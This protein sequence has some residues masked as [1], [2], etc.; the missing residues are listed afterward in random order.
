MMPVKNAA[1]ILAAALFV[2][3]VYSQNQGVVEGRLI[4]GTNPAKALAGLSVDAV[5]PASGMSAL[6]SAKTDSSGKFQFNGLPTIGPLLIRADYREVSYFSPVTFDERG[7]AQIEMRV[8]ETTASA[9]GIR[10]ANLQIAFKLASDGLRSIESYEIDNQ[11]K[12][13]STFMR[14]DG[15]FRF[16]KAPGIT[17]PPSLDVTS[18]GSSMPVTQAPLES[19]DGQSYYSLYALKPGMT[20]FEV[21]QQFPWQNGGFTFRKKFYQDV[22]SIKIGVIPQDMTLSG[23]GLARVQ[24]DATQNFAI[25]AIG[26]IKAGTEVVW[27]LS[28]GTPVA[29]APAPSSSQ[30]PEVQVMPMPNLI[31]QNALIIG[32]LLLLG[33]VLVL[34][35]ASSRVIVQPAGAKD[36]RTQEL[37]DRR[38][39][40]LNYIAALDA[41]YEKKALD[42]RRYVRLREQGKRHLRRIAVL[43]EKKR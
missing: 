19:A 33:L 42:R 12:P 29:D 35:Y 30:E 28:G 5:Q 27:T 4:D 41:Q 14:A 43:L 40:L 38:E 25:Y 37:G 3:P 11:T 20:T 8:Y 13:P 9:S 1:L 16:S 24:T 23:P 36:A 21:G 18:P 26:P 32:P 39:Q 31:G 15:S 7:K 17:D 2:P 22:A 34:W 10:L 6:K